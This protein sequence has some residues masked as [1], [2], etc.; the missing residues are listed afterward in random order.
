MKPI[1]N[2][3]IDRYR[4]RL[5]HALLGDISVLPPGAAREALEHIAVLDL[6]AIQPILE[7]MVADAMVTARRPN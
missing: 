7:D 6:A 5:Y 2:M 3:I 4:D 1:I